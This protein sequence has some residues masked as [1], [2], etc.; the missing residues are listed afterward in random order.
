MGCA[1]CWGLT[2]RV[3]LVTCGVILRSVLNTEIPHSIV[4]ASTPR[5]HPPGEG[6]S[7][8]LSRD[9]HGPQITGEHQK[10]HFLNA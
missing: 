8:V 6:G 3:I 4:T 10:T 7:L 1:H 5:P 9:N 2:V